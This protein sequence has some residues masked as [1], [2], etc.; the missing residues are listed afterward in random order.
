MYS[1]SFHRRSRSKS[2][3]TLIEL[4][5]VVAIIALLISI[6]LPSLKKARE[7]AK[8]VKCQSNERTMNIGLVMYFTEQ[9]I[10]PVAF[11]T[12]PSTGCVCGWC[13]WSYGGWLGKNNI[14]LA[15]NHGGGCFKIASKKRPLT[16]YLNKNVSDPL[17]F[18]G[19]GIPLE[20]LED[21]PLFK[22]PS[23]RSSYQANFVA[24]PI[25]T[26]S[27]YDDVGTSYQMNYY[28][29]NQ[30]NLPMSATGSQQD[31]DGD[32]MIEPTPGFCPNTTI[33]SCP[34]N[35]WPCRF[36]QGRQIWKKYSEKRTS[37]FVTVGEDPFDYAVVSRV[38]TLG[39]H[40]EFSKHNLGFLDTHVEYLKPKTAAAPGVSPGRGVD[41]TV[42]DEDLEAPWF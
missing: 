3:F 30:T 11:T 14:W 2:A 10:Y 27:A 32:G 23:D 5:V 21:Q 19:S 15:G 16:V 17:R 38:G 28:W 6:L 29:W 37:R 31:F 12:F 8:R 42:I 13:T 39:F 20:E 7:Q 9:N 35:N 36:D 33:G 26:F 4:L 41:W 34:A 1:L 25:Q 18:N 40:G 24:T 22:C